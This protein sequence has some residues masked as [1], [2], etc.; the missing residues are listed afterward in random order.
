[1]PFSS[2]QLNIINTAMDIIAKKGIKSFTIKNLARCVGVTE[3]A[4][5]RHFKSKDEIFSSILI[6]FNERILKIK[7]G[8]VRTN[9]TLDRMCK[10]FL[11]RMN[12][13]DKYPTLAII[14]FYEDFFIKQSSVADKITELKNRTLENLRNLIKTGQKR[15]EIRKDI[16]AD[17][18][19]FII[20][21]VV[22]ARV[23][24]WLLS[25]F[26]YRISNRGRKTLMAIKKI[27]KS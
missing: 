4:L 24:E 15:G 10:M 1:M 23:R 6:Y 12:L 14:I 11:K 2:R 17:D 25:G 13:L 16:N 5:Y 26:S 18:L 7:E 9:N 22:H 27:I 19:A 8:D 21:T 20:M 3:P